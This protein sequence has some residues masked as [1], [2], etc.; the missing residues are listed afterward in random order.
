MI[1]G[2]SAH[3]AVG[4]REEKRK[5]R[6]KRQEPTESFAWPALEPNELWKVR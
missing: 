4:R 5:R 3:L 2:S 6:K 1:D